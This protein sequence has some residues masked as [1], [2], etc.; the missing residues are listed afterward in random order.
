MNA[1]VQIA[2]YSTDDAIVIQQDNIVDFGDE[3][4]VFVLEGDI[5]KK[6]VLKL[7][8]RNGNTVLVDSGLVA[9]D[10]LINVGFQTLAD[11]DKVQVGQ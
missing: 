4:Y 3:Q 5:A 9:G 10:K 2:Q 7:G 8:S 11:G 1:N 6:K